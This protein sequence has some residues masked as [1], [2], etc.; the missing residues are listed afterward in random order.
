MWGAWALQFAVIGFLIGTI[1]AVPS[2]RTH[3]LH[4]RQKGPTDWIAGNVPGFLA[5]LLCPTLFVLCYVW[6]LV[7]SHSSREFELIKNLDRRVSV[8][9]Q[10]QHLRSTKPTV[11]FS[12]TCYHFESKVR[13]EGGEKQDYKLTV[14]THE[15]Q[16][17]FK[18]SEWQDAT[19]E[20]SGDSSVSM[21]N[22][23]LRKELQLADAARERYFREFND[24]CK[25]NHFDVTQ[26]FCRVM[27]VDGFKADHICFTD[28]RKAPWWANVVVY[29]LTVVLL[30]NVP[31]RMWVSSRS[32]CARLSVVKQVQ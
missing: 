3:V 2:Q 7:Q 12:A 13:Y 22:L 21:T 11:T 6:Y 28:P 17:V 8:Q 14:V 32:R 24:F 31:F 26:D 23:L 4:Q 16:K 20:L 18:F 1:I 5:A 15:A 25:K 27:E 30:V 9:D 10:L 29:L 19:P